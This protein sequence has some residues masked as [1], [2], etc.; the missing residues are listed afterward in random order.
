MVG[1]PVSATIRIRV[2]SLIAGN[3]TLTFSGASTG[4][5]VND[6]CSGAT[7]V[8]EGTWPFNTACSDTDGNAFATTTS[9]DPTDGPTNCFNDVWLL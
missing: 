9:C 1:V 3:F 7:P 4:A 6:H 2:A 5:P 8:I